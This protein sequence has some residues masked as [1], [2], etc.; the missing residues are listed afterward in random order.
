MLKN[1]NITVFVLGIGTT[2][3]ACVL[4]SIAIYF[5]SEKLFAV[6]DYIPYFSGIIIFIYY[7]FLINLELKIILLLFLLLKG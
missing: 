7:I 2:L 5:N 3:S 1:V 4:I 6:A